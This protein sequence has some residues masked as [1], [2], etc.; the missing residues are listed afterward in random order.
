[1][2]LTT[3]L[4]YLKALGVR[5]ETDFLDHRLVRIEDIDR[6]LNEYLNVGVS[7]R[8]EAQRVKGRTGPGVPDNAALI[9]ALKVGTISRNRVT[10]AV[11][12]HSGRNSTSW[13]MSWN[14]QCR[15]NSLRQMSA[16]YL[17][18]TAILQERR[19]CTAEQE[20]RRLGHLCIFDCRYRICETC[21][22]TYYNAWL[23]QNTRASRH[24]CNADALAKTS[25]SVSGKHGSHFMPGVDYADA[26]RFAGHEYRRNVPS[27]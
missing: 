4:A 6:E 27:A 25:H 16:A 24:C 1:M 10:R 23:A 3:H 21:K 7:P 19:R 15:T 2:I 20:Q 18:S 9:A 8:T 14:C 5:Y 22:Q 17:Q 13:S 11:N 12:L 26:Q